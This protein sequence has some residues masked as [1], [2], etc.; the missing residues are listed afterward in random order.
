MSS[1]NKDI[2]TNESQV[3]KS[4]VI[5]P[6]LSVQSN[7][8]GCLDTEKKF[9][10]EDVLDLIGFGKTQWIVLLT[11]G[12]LLMMVINETMGMSIITIASQCDF[13]SSSM[14]KAIMSAAAFIGILCSSYF[15]G[16]LCDTYGRKP[17]LMYTTLMGNL[18]SFISIFIANFWFYVF[19]RFV[20]GI[21][22]AG[23]SSTT[24]AFLGE[25]FIARHRPV[26]INYASMFVSLSM[27]YVPAVAWLVL[28]MNWSFEITDSFIF[29]PW[30]LLTIF[31]LL[32]GFI[33]V[34]ILST[35]PDSPKILMSMG[36]YDESY[37]AVNWIAKRNTGKCLQDFKVFKLLDETATEGDKI[38]LTSKSPSQ[39]LK[40]MWRETKPLFRKPH[41]TNFLISCT[42]MCGV[43]FCNSGM[44][45]W[46]PEIQ[47]RLG[48][49]T[50]E[51]K[52]TICQVIDAFIDQQNQ[53]ETEKICDDT[54]NT[55]SYIDSIT[56]GVA[57][58]GAYVILG[59]IINPLGRKVTI[60]GLL[61]ISAIC[62]ITLHWLLE[63][64]AIVVCFIL[65]LVLPGLCI[66]ILSGAVV[67]LVPTH[68]RGKAVCI[69]LM[70]GRS[71]S[72]IGSN[73]I[74]SLLESY[75]SITFG[76]F[77]GLILVCCL[78]TFTLPI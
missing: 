36:K 62:G 32:P 60:M 29:R 7:G 68:L 73:I 21:F 63:P 22:I 56:F 18:V 23:A 48:S 67:D 24:Y 1:I 66:S 65:F 13:D 58:I 76:V 59:M 71:G 69:C 75:C 5:A 55:K 8:N 44:G 20:V 9:L 50:D 4:I 40:Q 35:L 25:F 31:Y 19:L 27:T 43:F 53:N 38:L 77:Y 16:Y 14:D 11:C 2:N 45:L 33:A 41:V 39:V 10:Y 74:G 52:M 51:N 34:L 64:I 15:W 47:N 72:V 26:V 12:L 49:Y 78:L 6:R 3:Q 30:R 28:S 37:E 42:I 54:I 46:Y 57:Y 61:T 17:I 70:L